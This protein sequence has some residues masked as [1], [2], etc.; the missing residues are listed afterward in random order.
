MFVKWGAA[1][2]VIAQQKTII[3]VVEFLLKQRIVFM[4]FFIGR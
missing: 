3:S 4:K 2:V 1:M